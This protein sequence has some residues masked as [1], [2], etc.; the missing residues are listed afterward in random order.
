VTDGVYSVSS[1]ASLI[2]QE[3]LTKFEDD[4]Y[5]NLSNEEINRSKISDPLNILKGFEK[6]N[7]EN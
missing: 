2:V 1:K 5:Q 7:T 4:D 3:T 6:N